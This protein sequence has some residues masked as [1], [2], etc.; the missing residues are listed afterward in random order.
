MNR[1]IYVLITRLKTSGLTDTKTNLVAAFECEY[2]ANAALFDHNCKYKQDSYCG[3]P[4]IIRLNM[5]GG[6]Q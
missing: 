4:E 1:I 6:A 5:K 2:D 3:K